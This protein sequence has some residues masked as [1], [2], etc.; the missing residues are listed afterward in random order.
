MKLFMVLLYSVL[1]LAGSKGFAE[2]DPLD[3][4]KSKLDEV[5]SATRDTSVHCATC[6]MEN[7][8][9][10]SCDLGSLQRSELETLKRDEKFSSLMAGLD[11]NSSE[12]VLSN[13]TTGTSLGIKVAEKREG[14]KNKKIGKW[15][16]RNEGNDPEAQ[17]VSYQLGRFLQMTELVMPSAYYTADAKI[18]A[19]FKTFI[20][21][22][23]EKGRV[24]RENK[25][26]LLAAIQKNPTKMLGVFTGKMHQVEYPELIGNNTNN[27][28]HAHGVAKGILATNPMPS[29]NKKYTFS[30]LAEENDGVAPSAN[31]LDLS[32]ELSQIMVLDILTG[33]WDRW[34]GGNTEI[35]VNNRTGEASFVA[36][37]NGGASMSS[38]GSR[39]LQRY[40]SI[41]TRFDR[42]QIQRVERLRQLLSQNPACAARLLELRSNP[43]NLLSR[44]NALLAH[45]QESVNAYGESRVFFPN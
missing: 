24:R 33:Q 10:A 34:S 30:S 3:T 20:E 1:A 23:Q 17:V 18:L 35:M 5:F 44:V 32:R 13:K 28:N 31:E 11:L 9:S 16:P 14:K 39:V 8:G 45:V 27:I 41:V 22:K 38:D 42:K 6:K 25:A 40:A 4:V 12:F 36:R 7:P 29:K 15:A 43:K 37:D 19:K 26:A 21:G 2:S